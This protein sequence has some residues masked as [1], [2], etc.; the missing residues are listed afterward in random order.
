MN[1]IEVYD[2]TL[3]DGTQGAGIVFS[4]EDQLE[5]VRKL[6]ALGVKYIEGGQPGSNPKA[7]AFFRKVKELR[8]NNAV[9]TA[10]GSTCHPRKSARDDPNI[11]ALL[12]AGTEVVTIF[13]KS[14]D[15]H[16][17]KVL[18]VSLKKNLELI[19]QSIAYLKK[20]GRRVIYDAE[21][22]FDGF[23][24]RPDYALKTLAVAQDA[25]A[26]T[27]VLCDTNGGTMPSGVRTIVGEVRD[28]VKVK[29]GA[30]MHNDCGMAVANTIAAVD[31]GATHVD[32]TINGYGE[33][34]GN[35]D[36]CV[37]IPNIQLKLGLHCVSEEQLRMLAQ[38]AH[39]VS[40]LANVVPNDQQPFVGRNAFTHKGGMHI[41]GVQKARQAYEHIDPEIVGNR[42]HV[43]VSELSGR[44]GVAQ[45][46][47]ELGIELDKKHPET[48]KLLEKLKKLEQDG[49][50][51][52]AAE[53]SFQ[54]LLRKAT[55][56]HRTFFDLAGFRVIVEKRE[57]QPISEATIKVIV[58]GKEEHT[59]A[60]GNGPVDALDHALRK[61]LEKFYPDLKEMHLSD[62]KV[63]V[64][65]AQSGT[66]AK[67]RVLI[68]S[69]D[70]TST[71]R[72]VGVSEN[73]LEASYQAL[74]DSIEYKLLRDRES[75]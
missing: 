68:E 21:H 45:K 56:K 20:K 35:A 14:S 57:G 9:V 58:D 72:T 18:G 63:R 61:A 26:E 71:W 67:T 52:E 38:T 53:A 75:D 43:L 34:C 44:S 74:V 60:D 65:D 37:V 19:E 24:S 47:R 62:F 6:D 66:A 55:G 25:G 31:E 40:E 11:A 22:F 28:A 17:R 49:Y 36:L 32:G 73:I 8:L 42:R 10:F 4:L 2:T 48:H 50:Q 69:S 54:L 29:L 23:I 59:A 12:K 30:H 46:A 64:L 51:F 33:R 16:V 27:I 15:F 1:E 39:Y 13:G 7:A 5:I 70:A 3:R 41:H